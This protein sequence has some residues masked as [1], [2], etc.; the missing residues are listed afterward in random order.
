MGV[1]RIAGEAVH[2]YNARTTTRISTY[3]PARLV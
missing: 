1:Y 2:A 3:A